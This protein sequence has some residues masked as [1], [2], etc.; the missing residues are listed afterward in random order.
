MTKLEAIIKTFK[1]A[2]FNLTTV[3]G[4]DKGDLFIFSGKRPSINEIAEILDEKS[5]S[6]LDM[7]DGIFFRI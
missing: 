7:A 3:E 1:D 6:F 4:A 5:F 2:G